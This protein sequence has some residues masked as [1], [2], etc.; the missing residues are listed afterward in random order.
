MIGSLHIIRRAVKVSPKVLCIVVLLL[1]MMMVTGFFVPFGPLVEKNYILQ[2]VK[3]KCWQ[4]HTQ[5][6]L[7]VKNDS[8]FQV[9][10]FYKPPRGRGHGQSS[11]NI[12]R[13]DQ[14]AKL[15]KI[16]ASFS[17]VGSHLNKTM[18]EGKYLSY[19]AIKLYLHITQY[20]MMF[21]KVYNI[22]LL[23]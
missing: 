5:C 17:R 11:V 6:L 20:S 23:Y 15:T 22:N 7:W 8:I 10:N 16:S 3:K 9:F 21:Q 13:T 14:R 4:N 1:M 19:R 12:P 18:S 2:K